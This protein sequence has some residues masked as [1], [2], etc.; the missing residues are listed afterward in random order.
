MKTS[1]KSYRT[2]KQ[3]RIVTALILS[4]ILSV[5]S[6]LS[7]L[8]SATA[9]VANQTPETAN[10]VLKGNIK[11]ASLPRPVASAVKQHLSNKEQI[12]VK[13]LEI[14]NYSQQT[15]RN[16][17]LDV[18]NPDE[19]CTQALVPGWRVVLSNGTQRWTYHTNN[20][21][22]YLRLAQRNTSESNLPKA[23]KDAVLEAA[24][25]R[26]DL[27]TGKLTILEAEQ[28]T[29]SDGC[30]GLGR[31][32]ESCIAS[33]V[34]GWRVVI[35]ASEQSLVYH[36]NTTGSV[37]R[38]NEKE[39]EIKDGRAPQKVLPG[40]VSDAVL[41]AASQFTGLRT[42]QL[43]IVNYERITTDG[44]LSLPRPREACTKI[45]LSAWKVTVEGGKQRLVYHAHP[46]GKDVRLNEAASR[47]TSLPQSVAN[48]VL[49]EA[50]E[51]SGL[52][53][54]SLSIIG[55]KPTQWTDGCEK[56]TY[57]NPCDPIRVSGW[58]VTVG[59][60]LDR[61]VFLSD[62]SGSRIQ[63]SQQY[64]ETPNVNLPKDIVERILVRASKRSGVPISQL[65]I[66]EVEQRQWRD[67]CLG[68]VDPLALCAAVI[69]PGWEVT[70]SDGRQRL[71]YRVGESGV[72]ILDEKASGIAQ[73]SGVKPV[74]IRR[75]EL[76]PPL[77]SG[78]VFR[79]ISSGGIIGRTYETVLLNDGRLIRVRFGDENDSE[80]SVRRIP[81]NQVEQFE[82]LLE[83]QG[84]MFNNMSYP[85]S[86][87]AADY[88]TY[89][90][91]SRDGTV[92]YNDISQNSLPEDLRLVVNTWNRISRSYE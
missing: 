91:T 1:L 13:Q 10:Q 8:K 11:T 6:G 88:M 57:P 37:I 35:G 53:S 25:R 84:N 64:D 24:S 58:Q 30:L 46:N 78:V 49:E 65:Q 47:F 85:A 20:N 2:T 15:W 42:S 32:N 77:D 50:K 81:L 48:A 21:G 70:V 34:P 43:R 19:F 80:R 39:S 92:Q 45:A 67:S 61:W 7:V 66:V 52:R 14:I 36:T 12:P 28:R 59:A 74:S 87:G 3:G 54:S 72:V 75:S 73:N 60:G 83:Q 31:A 86:R 62:Q 33:L 38:L 44:C 18:P 22:R 76:P 23:V 82:R 41:K 40:K 17:C 68:I 16:G 55:Y 9:A 79:Q 71:V 63:L 69:V 29:W 26:L 56:Q 27:S 5:G 90:L 4:G 51:V 89:T